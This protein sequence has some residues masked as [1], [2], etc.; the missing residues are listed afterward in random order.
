LV[1]EIRPAWQ[2]GDAA[3]HEPGGLSSMVVQAWLEYGWLRLRRFDYWNPAHIPTNCSNKLFRANAPGAMSAG[4]NMKKHDDAVGTS[5]FTVRYF[6][7]DQIRR[8]TGY[9]SDTPLS[10][11]HALMK[12]PHSQ[13]L[14]PSSITPTKLVQPPA[15]PFAAG[16]GPN[17]T[18]TVGMGLS[19]KIAN[20]LQRSPDLGIPMA[21]SESVVP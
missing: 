17:Y 5:N 21:I 16:E 6:H 20:P 1:V 18:T 13:G 15:F 14:R 7:R 12:A 11:N 3:P 10:L 4:V 8:D 2:S 19:K 9:Y